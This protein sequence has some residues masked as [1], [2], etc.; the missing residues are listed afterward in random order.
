M[1]PGRP[2]SCSISLDQNIQRNWTLY[3]GPHCL[4]VFLSERFSN[5]PNCLTLLPGRPAPELREW[6]PPPQHHRRHQHRRPDR[7]RGGHGRIHQQLQQELRRLLPQRH[8]GR[9]GLQAGLPLPGSSGSEQGCPCSYF[10]RSCDEI[11]ATITM[12]TMT[13]FIPILITWSPLSSRLLKFNSNLVQI[14]IK[15]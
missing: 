14:I 8:W 10:W 4:E 2:R 13:L 11:D 3:V 15:K 1:L 7:R 12:T 5:Q 6:L 9:H